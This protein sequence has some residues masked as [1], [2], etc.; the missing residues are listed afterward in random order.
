MASFFFSFR[1]AATADCFVLC[2][3]AV[4]EFQNIFR[5]WKRV[6]ESPILMPRGA[7]LAEAGTFN[8]PVVIRNGNFRDALR[9][10]DA[11]GT[12]RLGYV[13]SGDGIT[14]RGCSARC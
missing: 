13:E 1:A 3:A 9:A 4:A 2:T 12:S 8:P 11:A 14:S 7:D 6:T 10:Q 5:D